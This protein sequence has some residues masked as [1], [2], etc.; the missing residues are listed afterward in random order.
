VAHLQRLF[1]AT[2]ERDIADKEQL[3]AVVEKIDPASIPET[4]RVSQRR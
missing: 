2:Q 1:E 4:R 3:I